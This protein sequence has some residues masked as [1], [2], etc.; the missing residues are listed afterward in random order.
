MT[1]GGYDDSR[2]V[3][4]DVTF[5]MHPDNTRD[6]VAGLQTITTDF[7]GRQNGSILSDPI[8]VFIDST[9]PDL[10]LPVETCKAFEQTLGLIWNETYQTY[11]VDDNLHQ[12]LIN[13]NISITFT[14]GDSKTSS[15]TVDITLPYASFD[16]VLDYPLVPQN[17]SG[18][19]YFPLLRA[20]ND[21]QYTLGRT[22]L[23]EA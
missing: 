12:K 13:D 5:H 6:L 16:L 22:F 9:I 10:Y 17:M 21:T 4:N 14:L 18:I 1:L 3:D 7:S 11:F 23:Q 20:D 2:F 19:R 15:P 8:Y